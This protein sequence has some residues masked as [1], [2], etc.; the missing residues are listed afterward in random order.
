MGNTGGNLECGSAQPSLFLSFFCLNLDSQREQWWLLTSEWTYF[1]WFKKRHLCSEGFCTQITFLFLM[2][3]WMMNQ[4]MVLLG[5]LRMKLSCTLITLKWSIYMF[6]FNM[7]LFQIWLTEFILTMWTNSFQEVLMFFQWRIELCNSFSKSFE[8]VLPAKFTAS[9][10]I[11]VIAHVVKKISFTFWTSQRNPRMF[12]EVTF[13]QESFIIKILFSTSDCHSMNI[14]FK[15]LDMF[16]FVLFTL[17]F[18]G[19][20]W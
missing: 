20:T 6:K 13:G 12:D 9:V 10:K 3:L 17:L 14:F 19:A 4:F 7:L 8:P 2:K 18:I 5:L 11:Q 15:Q 16:Q 1:M